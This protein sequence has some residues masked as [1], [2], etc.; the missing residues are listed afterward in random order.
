GVAALAK[1][2]ASVTKLKL[3]RMRPSVSKRS[4]LSTSACLRFCRYARSAR[5]NSGQPSRD[6]YFRHKRR[7]A[8]SSAVTVDPLPAVRR[9]LRGRKPY[10]RTA[11]N[12][13]F[14]VATFVAERP[15]APYSTYLSRSSDNPRCTTRGI[16]S[17]VN[18]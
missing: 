2:P 4:G 6:S 18:G 15:R 11:G 13:A 16:P 8:A 14:R 17:T 9:F 7:T 12:L 10:E 5:A 3:H 1:R